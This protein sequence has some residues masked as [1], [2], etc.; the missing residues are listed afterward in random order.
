MNIPLTI[1]SYFVGNV[2]LSVNTDGRGILINNIDIDLYTNDCDD[3]K[4]GQLQLLIE[5]LP[6]GIKL[7]SLS[8]DDIDSIIKE[9]DR[10]KLSKI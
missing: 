10:I 8:T 3:N 7:M 2:S 1:N 4:N 9:L 6:I 5:S